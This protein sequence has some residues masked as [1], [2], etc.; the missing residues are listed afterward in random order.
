MLQRLDRSLS[1]KGEGTVLDSR[2]VLNIF[3]LENAR[4]APSHVCA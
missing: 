2:C 1:E 4:Q 3:R